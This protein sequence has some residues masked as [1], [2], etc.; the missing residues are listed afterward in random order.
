MEGG[1]N[2]PEDQVVIGPPM[3]KCPH[4]GKETSEN[5]IV[6]EHCGRSLLAGPPWDKP[7]WKD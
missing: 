6:C 3:I 2:I 1:I 5:L 7:L 4:C